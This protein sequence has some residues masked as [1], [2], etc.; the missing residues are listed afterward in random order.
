M[1]VAVNQSASL[2]FGIMLDKDGK[3]ERVN[4]VAR[5]NLFCKGDRV[6]S[7]NG[8]DV[9][10]DEQMRDVLRMVPQSAETVVFSVERGE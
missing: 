1:T 7:V 10:N 2:P 9:E 4:D 5:F 8:I 6:C 3:V